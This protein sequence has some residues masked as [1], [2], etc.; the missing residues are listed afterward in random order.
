MRIFSLKGL[1]SMD[2]PVPSSP[3]V[4]SAVIVWLAGFA[5]CNPDDG[6]E[7]VTAG[8]GFVA[9]GVDAGMDA[10]APPST[11]FT[12]DDAGAVDDDAS[13]ATDGGAVT[14]AATAVST[15]AANGPE[16]QGPDLPHAAGNAAAGQDVFRFETFGNEGFWTDAVRLP[17]GL[18]AQNLT[19][20]RLLAW[21]LSVNIDAVAPDTRAS[22]TA[23]TTSGGGAPGSALNDPAT[24]IRL[25]NANAVVG[26][27]VKDSDGDGALNVAA[28]D[29]LGITCALCH[30]ITDGSTVASP[31]NLGGGGIGRQIDGPVPYNLNLG[32]LLAA[33]DNSRALFPFLQIKL[34]A[35]SGRS[36]GRAPDSAALTVASS[37]ADVDAFLGNPNYYP[38]GMFD[39]FPDG[40]GAPQSIAPLFRTDLSAPYGAAGEIAGLDN[41]SNFIYT[42]ALDPTT[43][44][45]SA[46]ENFLKAMNGVTA[47]AELAVDYQQI[48]ADTGVAGFPFV[49]ASAPDDGA[50][51]SEAAPVGLRVDG[52]RLL[53]LN[54][55]TDGLHPPPAPSGL[56]GDPI[57][58]GR[59]AFREHC[60]GCHNVDQSLRVP[61]LT[62]A[63]AAV[64]PAYAPV[65]LADR[66]LE[67]P[68]RP[69]ALAPIE[70]DPS[71]IFDDQVVVDDASRRG[72]LRGSALPL[73]MD[74]SRKD[75][76]LRDGEVTSLDRLLDPARGSATPHPFFIADAAARAA[77]V[78]FLKS[79]TDQSR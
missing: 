4:F 2:A 50:A 45:S 5:A 44:V 54:A 56:E 63:E 61:T 26:L 20:A 36:I 30:A 48:L 47:G 32:A 23:A 42:V 19:L 7:R 33:A 71:T 15:D 74:L 49:R 60:T 65:L 55:Y 29:K 22:L 52:Q 78:T 11:V 62:V 14:D 28:G 76:F 27:V 70:D 24:A 31:N 58:A 69:Q 13:A 40:N 67:L 51:G 3:V 8:P 34:T 17:S 35:M 59:E 21:G 9:D 37:E 39:D 68:F 16:N 41:F 79:L 77:L 25:L 73:L 72:D 57:G 66:P 46:G 10:D 1:I 75:R 18:L 12:S 38:P 53:D 43:L 6:P 64:F